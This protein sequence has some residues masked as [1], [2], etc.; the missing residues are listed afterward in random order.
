MVQVIQILNRKGDEAQVF[1]LE[2]EGQVSLAEEYFSKYAGHGF[3]AV[4]TS[5]NHKEMLRE[6]S[7]LAE[8]ITMMPQI[9][10]G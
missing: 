7:P 3:I 10:G 9:S 5:G 6:Y 1:D 2:V 8:E 4:N